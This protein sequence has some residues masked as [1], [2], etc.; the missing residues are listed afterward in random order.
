MNKGDNSVQGRRWNRARNRDRNKARFRIRQRIAFACSDTSIHDEK[1]T[2]TCHL[3]HHREIIF[4]DTCKTDADEM[5]RSTFNLVSNGSASAF[6]LKRI[7]ENYDLLSSPLDS[8]FMS[9]FKITTLCTSRFGRDYA[10]AV[11]FYKNKIP[12]C[13][14]I[15]YA[16]LIGEYGVISALLAGGINPCYLREDGPTRKV[17]KNEV[18]KLAM[19]KLVAELIPSSLAVYV[20]KSIFMMKMWSV[21]RSFEDSESSNINQCPLCYT[22][23]TEP[24]LTF[25]AHCKH[26]C[27]ELC[28]WEIVLQKIDK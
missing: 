24:L 14:L 18:S 8:T 2:D 27:C 25:Q 15:E 22:M 1:A 13:S 19:K 3:P 6:S 12:C 11:L 5:I 17:G 7:S 26:I 28:M 16:S 23:T 9:N 4:E 10:E 20:I 21:V